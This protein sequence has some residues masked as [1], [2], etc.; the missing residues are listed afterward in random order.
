MLV[1]YKT[2]RREVG[3]TRFTRTWLIDLVF[4]SFRLFDNFTCTYVP[5][6]YVV[7]VN[8]HNTYVHVYNY[9]VVNVHVIYI[10]M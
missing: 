10:R 9:V 6:T 8:V 4:P 2:F 7:N 5:R 1:W 3:G